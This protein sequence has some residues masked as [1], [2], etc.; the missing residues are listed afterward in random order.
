MG[1]CVRNLGRMNCECG[2][3]DVGN[4]VPKRLVH[5]TMFK[6]WVLQFGSIATQGICDLA[7]QLAKYLKLQNPSFV[8]VHMV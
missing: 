4:K 1:F 5:T 3:V 8:I 7:K 6:T 2:Y